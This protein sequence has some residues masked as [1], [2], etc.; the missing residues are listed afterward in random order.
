MGA[1]EPTGGSSGDPGS[2]CP[3]VWRWVHWVRSSDG[4]REESARS[5]CNL[6]VGTCRIDR[7]QLQPKHSSSKLHGLRSPL[8]RWPP[9]C[10]PGFGEH[11]GRAFP[12]AVLEE[13]GLQM[14]E[15]DWG[16]G[17]SDT[18]GGWP[19]GKLRVR[20]E[21]EGPREGG[22]KSLGG[23]HRAGLGLKGQAESTAFLLSF[24]RAVQVLLFFL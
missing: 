13:G 6:P 7:E 1:G 9:A 24:Q 23:R 21:Q 3:S 17:G 10:S 5:R 19:W 2:S 15:G 11:H 18:G 22:K 16:A 14:A 4:Y 8:A 20:W 12:E